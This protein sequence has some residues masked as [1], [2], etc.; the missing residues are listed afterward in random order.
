MSDEGPAKEVP[1][2]RW[3]IGPIG[4]HYIKTGDV[5]TCYCG[6]PA[7][8]ARDETG[9]PYQACPTHGRIM[10]APGMTHIEIE[11]M[12][13]LAAQGLNAMR[14]VQSHLEMMDS[15]LIDPLKKRR[16]DGED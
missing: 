5:W 2:G 3:G 15:P 16:G 1:G 12:K 4:N 9:K 11:A 13:D 8:T 7:L 14:T 10:A 6:V